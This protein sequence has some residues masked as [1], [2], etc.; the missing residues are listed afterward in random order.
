MFRLSK[1]NNVLIERRG[2]GEGGGGG[3]RYNVS[4]HR[5][6]KKWDGPTQLNE[7]EDIEQ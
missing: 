2:G 3:G 4:V 1:Q 6:C 7:K 5:E